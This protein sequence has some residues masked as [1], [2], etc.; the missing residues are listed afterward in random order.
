LNSS[1]C[2]GWGTRER[3]SVTGFRIRIVVKGRVGPNVRSLLADLDAEVVPRHNMFSVGPGWLPELLMALEALHQRGVE[4]DRI[5]SLARLEYPTCTE[6][7][8]DGDTAG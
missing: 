3:P 5:C 1:N 7:P 4:V 2:D 6:R 8:A